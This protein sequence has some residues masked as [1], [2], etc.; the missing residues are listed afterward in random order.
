MIGID[1]ETTALSPDEGRVRL[2]Q[3]S[4]GEETHVADAKDAD[5]REVRDVLLSMPRSGPPTPI[6]SRAWLSITA[7]LG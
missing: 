1:F 4:N 2:I 6:P 5:P 3:M 7:P